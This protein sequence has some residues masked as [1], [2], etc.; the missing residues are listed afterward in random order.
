MEQKPAWL[1]EQ[2]ITLPNGASA[3]W[4]YDREGDV[5][6]IFFD[7][8]PASATAELA[9]GILLRFDYERQQ[10]LSIGFIAASKRMQRME[11]GQ[12]VLALTGLDR[13]PAPERQLVLAMLQAPPLNT[14]LQ[15]YSFQPGTRARTIPVALVTPALPLAA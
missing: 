8:A 12:P 14:V 13:L 6:E 3:L 10:P 7:H 11:F 5:L 1:Y 2:E 15:L 4:S 9:D